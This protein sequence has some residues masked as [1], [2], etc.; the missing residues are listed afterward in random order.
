VEKQFFAALNR[1]RNFPAFGS[2]SWLSAEV[3]T[4][5]GGFL[6]GRATD[7]G[8]NI[9]GIHDQVGS[10]AS[11]LI[12]EAKTVDE[13]VLHTFSRCTTSFRVVH[14]LDWPGLGG[15]LPDHD[16]EVALVEDVHCDFE[17][18]SARRSR[19]NRSRPREP[20]G[21]RFRDQARRKVFV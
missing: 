8:G 18:V 6:F 11:L 17:H 20:E 4:N 13:D 19:A 5:R 15:F 3:R 9:E 14:V 12:D 7:T 2:W 1:F 21:Q 10:P 16:R